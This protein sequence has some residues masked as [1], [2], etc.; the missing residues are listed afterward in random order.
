MLAHLD[1]HTEAVPLLH[2]M[3]AFPQPHIIDGPLQTLKTTGLPVSGN[4]YEC[5]RTNEETQIE[6]I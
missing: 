1:A 6:T 3:P 4:K 5:M 2:C